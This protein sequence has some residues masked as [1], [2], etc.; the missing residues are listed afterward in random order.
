MGLG[1]L[2]NWLGFLDGS[3][4]YRRHQHSAECFLGMAHRC[5]QN[6]RENGMLPPLKVTEVH[7]PRSAARDFECSPVLR[8]SQNPRQPR[9]HDAG[10]VTSDML[11]SQLVSS[12]RTRV[13]PHQTTE[14][15]KR[16][17]TSNAG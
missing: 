4:F 7:Q 12:R 15:P 2:A 8:R 11:S 13:V 9:A 5:G 10:R 1:L 17:A 16:A 6:Q 3:E 14:R